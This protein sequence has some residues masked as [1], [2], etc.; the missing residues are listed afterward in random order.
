MSAT[1][2]H[3][4]TPAAQAHRKAMRRLR[5]Q[6]PWP[7]VAQVASLD[8]EA[9]RAVVGRLDCAMAAAG[10]PYYTRDENGVA[11]YVGPRAS[12]HDGRSE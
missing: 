12:E 6:G 7:T 10:S 8:D 1:R 2:R 9:I 11:V 5:S 3:A 4:P